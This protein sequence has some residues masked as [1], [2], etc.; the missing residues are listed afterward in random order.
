[1]KIIIILLLA[2]CGQTLSAQKKEKPKDTGKGEVFKKPYQKADVKP[3]DKTCY[4]Y[5]FHF[6][7][8]YNGMER[9]GCFYV[10]DQNGIV[11]SFGFDGKFSN[12]A[13]DFSSPDFYAY[14]YSMKGN[15]YTYFNES[16]KT[17]RGYETIHIVRTA[18]TDSNNPEMMFKNLKMKA[19]DEVQEFGSDVLVKGRKYRS[20]DS[21]IEIWL[22]TDANY[23]IQIETLDFLGAYGVGFLQ[24]SKGVFNMLGYDYDKSYSHI[25]FYKEM[26]SPECFFPSMFKKEETNRNQT[27]QRDLNEQIANTEAE[28]N[29]NKIS[30]S[31]CAPLKDAWLQ[32]VQKQTKSTSSTMQ[33]ASNNKVNV[34]SQRSMEAV[35]GKYDPFDTYSALKKEDQYKVCEIDD[36]LARNLY[37]DN[38]ERERAVYRK[39]CLVQRIEEVGKIE[40]EYHKAKQ[41]N[42]NNP[43]KLSNELKRIMPKVSQVYGLY[44]CS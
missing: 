29:N 30:T 37:R 24:T 44:K 39:S 6:K 14:I 11:L 8:V 26:E 41:V 22:E 36:G 17:N 33:K 31:K 7:G 35:Y 43:Q 28:I 9:S 20:A 18:N 42:S 25:T 1:M 15:T 10:N 21:D 19:T 4:N 16:K 13:Y 5:I 40:E 23:P 34:T 32:S 38:A 3:N 2:L 27:L 12:C